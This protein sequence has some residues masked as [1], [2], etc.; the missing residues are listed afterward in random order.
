M[1]LDHMSVSERV[2]ERLEG[3]RGGERRGEKS[4][5]KEKNVRMMTVELSVAAVCSVYLRTSCVTCE[6]CQAAPQPL[7]AA[8]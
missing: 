4:G 3:S 6:N 1:S 5:E 7:T 8:W 2:G